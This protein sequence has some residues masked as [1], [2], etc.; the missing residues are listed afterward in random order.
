VRLAK[1]YS[2]VDHQLLRRGFMQRLSTEALALYLFLV[3]VSDRDG[4]SYYAQTTV[5]DILR[6]SGLVF[7]RALAELCSCG[8][9]SYQQPYFWVK[10]L[11]T[12][13]GIHVKS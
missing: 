11:S 9:V 7:S 6:L 3:V 12:P 4:K 2:I 1:S 5:M 13:G 10:A 8:L